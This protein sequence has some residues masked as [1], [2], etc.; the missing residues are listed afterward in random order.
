MVLGCIYLFDCGCSHTRL[1]SAEFGEIGLIEVGKVSVLVFA[2]V[3][4]E[5]S[6]LG[7]YFQSLVIFFQ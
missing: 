6:S 5:F 7:W 1:N 4:D 3:M 2:I